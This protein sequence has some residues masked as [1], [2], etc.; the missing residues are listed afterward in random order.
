MEESKRESKKG[1][2]R[3][4]MK[5]KGNERK[6][7]KDW[8]K[9]FHA[10]NIHIGLGALYECFLF[11]GKSVRVLYSFTNWMNDFCS[12]YGTYCEFLVTYA[13]TWEY[14][15]APTWFIRTCV[16]ICEHFF[17][18]VYVYTCIMYSIYLYILFIHVHMYV[19]CI[20]TFKFIHASR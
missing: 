9:R 16:C 15:R 11:Y 13:H 17:F 6:R 1:K 8:K 7:E 19:W 20:H 4:R 12:F 18:N 2:Q 14:V 5:K 3:I 10:A